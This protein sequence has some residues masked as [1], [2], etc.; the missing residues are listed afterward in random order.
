ME[1]GFRMGTYVHPW[2]IP[3][4]V[5]PKPLQHYKVISLQLKKNKLIEILKKPVSFLIH[6]LLM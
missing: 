2:L 5:W 4:N 6:S 1:G 3:V